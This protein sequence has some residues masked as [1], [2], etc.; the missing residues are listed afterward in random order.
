MT[1]RAPSIDH[2]YFISQ[3]GKIVDNAKTYEDAMSKGKALKRGNPQLRVDI[4][5][6]GI[7]IELN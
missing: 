3:K 1:Y 5:Y 7:A 4:Q 2:G 6:D